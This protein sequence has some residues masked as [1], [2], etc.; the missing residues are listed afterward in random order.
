MD[1]GARQDM[2]T[3]G[4]RHRQVWPLISYVVDVCAH[5]YLYLRHD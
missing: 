1:Q 2:H 4:S 3:I 5:S